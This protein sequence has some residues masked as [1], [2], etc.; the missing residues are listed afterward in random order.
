MADAHEVYTTTVLQCLLVSIESALVTA[1][2]FVYAHIADVRVCE[3]DHLITVGRIGHNLLIAR[4]RCIEN[5]F[6]HA[7]P[8]C[9]KAPARHN[10]A[11]G[12]N[13]SPILRRPWL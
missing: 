13:Q 9:A 1:R 5:D 4:H 6:C 8:G 7:R 10:S 3:T 11:I 2:T 12:K